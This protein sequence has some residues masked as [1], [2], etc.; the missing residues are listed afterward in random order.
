MLLKKY[1]DNRYL[2]KMMVKALY[3]LVKYRNGGILETVH[4]SYKS[5][6]GNSQQLYHFIKKLKAKELN[7]VALRFAWNAMQRHP[8]DEAIKK[9]TN[10]LFK[11]LVFEAKLTPDYFFD[12][13]RQELM[14][15]EKIDTVA[16]SEEN[17]EVLSKYEKIRRKKVVKEIKGEEYFLKYAMVDLMNDNDFIEAFENQM[18]DYEKDQEENSE[19]YSVIR[20]KRR[21]KRLER[22][23][24]R[25]KGKALGIEKIVLVDPM[26]RVID[27]R[28]H[29]EV[30]YLVSEIS[31]MNY[32]EQLGRNADRTKLEVSIL[33]TNKLKVS[34]IEK[35][36][37]H[38]ILNEWLSELLDHDGDNMELTI[39][40]QEQVKYLTEKYN[41]KYFGWTG[42]ISIRK[43]KGPEAFWFLVGGIVTLYLFPYALYNLFTPDY[44]TVYYMVLFDIETG[45][46]EFVQ[47][48][49]MNTKDARD[50]INSNLY[51]SFHQIRAEKKEKEQ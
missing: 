51:D 1:P 27:Q 7:V 10:E 41:T 24:I 12:K 9:H 42:V 23:I 31:Q 17:M 20:E 21:E 43:S 25:K 13:S 22:K 44:D 30:S 50:L 18:D 46:A 39:G 29:T 11:E 19:D 49:Y 15:V 6:E 47:Q 32:I 48:H 33:N 40:N 4:D 14:V 45:K 36:N 8:E 28:R 2:D 26:Y 38:A 16:D 37:D 35:F 3:G 5:I 34:D